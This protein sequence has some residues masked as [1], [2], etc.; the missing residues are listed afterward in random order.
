MIKDQLL[1]SWTTGV[2]AAVE[3]SWPPGSISQVAVDQQI[4]SSTPRAWNNIFAIIGDRAVPR[5][6]D[7]C[8]TMNAT[9]V[10]GSSAIIGQHA[11]R[12]RDP[13]TSD[14]T[15]YHLLASE[16]GRL[17]WMNE[18]GTVT[19]ISAS[20]F[21]SGFYPPS[22]ATLN[23]HCFV[24]NGQEKFKLYGTTK[25]NFGI[26]RPVVGTAAGNAG[27]AGMLDGTFELAFTFSN[28]VSGHESSRSDPTGEVVA[29]FNKIDITN[30]P[31]TTDTQVDQVH[32]Y[33]RNKATQTEFYRIDTVTVGTTTATVDVV[34]DEYELTNVGPSINENNPPPTSVKYVVAHKNRLFA[35]DDSQIYW[36]KTGFPEAFDPDAYDYVNQNDGQKITGMASIPGGYLII[37]K[38][39]SYYVL[40]GDTPGVWAISRL[41]PEVGCLSARSITLG[42]DALY[43]WAEQGVVRLEFGSLSTPQLIADNRIS[44]VIS[45]RNMNFGER[46]RICGAFQ[47]T[48]QRVLFAFPEIGQT[49]NTRIIVWS[50]RLGCWESDRWDPIDSASLAMAN[51]SDSEPFV[52]AGGYAGQVFKL[53][54]GAVDGVPSGTTSGTFTATAVSQ[55]DITVSGATFLTSGGKLI[56]RKVTV[57]DANNVVKTTFVRPHVTTNTSTVL[58]LSHAVSNLTIGAT[59]TVIVG[60]PDWQFDTAWIDGGAAFEKKRLLFL[61][62]MSMQYGQTMYVDLLRNRLG[63]TLEEE[64]FANIASEG[65]LWNA[66]NWNDGSLWNDIEVTYDRIRGGRTGVS[67]AA[68]FRNPYPL[69]PMLLLKAGFRMEVGD[70]KLG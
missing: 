58:T 11:Y 19:A 3:V 68:R 56:E 40:D 14:V 63:I 8:V 29:A 5:T 17:D 59:Y 27:S 34:V 16:N 38:E 21:T 7:G 39:D 55:T 9:P 66:F 28:S 52:M 41:G 65:V 69:Q 50:S 12:W 61:Y 30:I 48:G 20:A 26:D 51:D 10:T 23:N 49:R 64:R 45:R 37:F 15:Q 46:Q 25:Q 4:A 32:I 57:L 18:S 53:G 62:V 70:D 60:G 22:F 43:W 24:V 36:S 13:D 1:T 35:A 67:F 6:R 2:M 47:I 44:A 33:I 42:A 31:T 54:V